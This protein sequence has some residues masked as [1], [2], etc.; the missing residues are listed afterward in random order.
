[1]DEATVNKLIEAFSWGC[2]DVE[3]CVYAGIS[4]QTLYSYCEKHPEFTDRKEALKD[5]PT[6]KAK[7]IIF[8]SLE[9][10]E[11]N[12][13]NRVI[14]R[15]EGTKIKQDITSGGQPI[16]N[17]WHIHPVTTKGNESS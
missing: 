5:T 11:L 12:T 2:T 15:K 6:M 16:K 14:D 8:N 3:A 17:E 7:R 9:K 4:K 1:M 13:A 10:Q